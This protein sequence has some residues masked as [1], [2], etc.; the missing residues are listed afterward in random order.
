MGLQQEWDD[1]ARSMCARLEAIE[2]ALESNDPQR[3][4][5]TWDR[6]TKPYRAASQRFVALALDVIDHHFPEH[7]RR[8]WGLELTVLYP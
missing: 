6:N 3:I 8:R 4:R 1:H 5:D 2:R 7:V